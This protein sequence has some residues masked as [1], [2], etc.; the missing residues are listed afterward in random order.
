MYF[1]SKNIWDMSYRRSGAPKVYIILN[2][3]LASPFSTLS[4]AQ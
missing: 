3:L 4:L 1:K 2:T